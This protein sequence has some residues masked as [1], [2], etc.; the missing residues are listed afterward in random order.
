VLGVPWP[1]RFEAEGGVVAEVH[2]ISRH[3]GGLRG[4]VVIVDPA[5]GRESFRFQGAADYV[6]ALRIVLSARRTCS[7]AWPEVLRAEDDCETCGGSGTAP[8]GSTCACF[9]WHLV[10]A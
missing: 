6:D 9:G 5:L 3:V 10:T 4:R 7:A 2:A 8:D 1:P